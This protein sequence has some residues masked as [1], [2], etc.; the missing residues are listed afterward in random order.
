[1]ELQ[2]NDRIVFAPFEIVEKC[3]PFIIGMDYLHQ[4]GLCITCLANPGIEATQ[5]PEPQE[6][7][8]PA[9]LPGEIPKEEKK[10]NLS[11]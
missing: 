6:D 4:L 10:K 11:I 3:Y 5:L 8:K 1:M 9:L 2:F 7:Q